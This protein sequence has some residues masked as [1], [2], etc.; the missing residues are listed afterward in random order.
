MPPFLAFFKC[1][2]SILTRG[3]LR[4]LSRAV[5][6]TTARLQLPCAS[7]IDSNWGW[8]DRQKLAE[9]KHEAARYLLVTEADGALAAFVHL[10]FDWEDDDLVLYVYEIQLAERVRRKGLGKF[11]MQTVELIARRANMDGVLLTVLGSD[12]DA[13]AFYRAI[14]FSEIY[15]TEEELETDEVEA[16]TGKKY[17]LMSKDFRPDPH[18]AHEHDADGNCQK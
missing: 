10:R 14:G 1:F 7:Y 18:A 17:S 5:C 16:A 3:S 11:L 15:S 9:L 13:M 4:A 6:C 12:A 2:V 8:D